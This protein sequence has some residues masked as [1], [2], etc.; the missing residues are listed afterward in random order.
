MELEKRFIYIYFRRYSYYHC[1]GNGQCTCDDCKKLGR[2]ALG[3]TDDFYKLKK[4]GY[5][6]CYD[7][8][9]LRL[10][11]KYFN[12]MVKVGIKNEK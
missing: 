1:K 3:W 11:N 4:K 6:L 12:D 8:L 10:Y 2:H 9:K 5:T 7:C